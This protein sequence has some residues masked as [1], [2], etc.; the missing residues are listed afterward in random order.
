LAEQRK[1]VLRQPI[2]QPAISRKPDAAFSKGFG[3]V[4]DQDVFVI[5]GVN[6]FHAD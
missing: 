5:D 3:R 1:R 4:C 2:S 6:A